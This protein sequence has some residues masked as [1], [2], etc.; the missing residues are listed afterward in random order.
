MPTRESM[1]IKEKVEKFKENYPKIL[2]RK[3]D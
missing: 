2:K 3:R 1:G